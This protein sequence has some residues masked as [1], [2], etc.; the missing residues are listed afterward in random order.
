MTP[1]PFPLHFVCLC[2]CLSFHFSRSA[3]P[4]SCFLLACRVGT[5]FVARAQRAAVNLTATSNVLFQSSPQSLHLSSQLLSNLHIGLWSS[6]T[7]RLKKNGSNKTLIIEMFYKYAGNTCHNIIERLRSRKNSIRTS[8]D[9]DLNKWKSQI[10]HK[11]SPTKPRCWFWFVGNFLAFKR[12]LKTK[13]FKKRDVI[14]LK[15]Q[16][17]CSAL[18]W[19][20]VY[21]CVIQRLVTSDGSNGTQND[22]GH[23]DNEWG[24][25]SRRLG[26]PHIYI[27]CMIWKYVWVL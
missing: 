26:G 21:W 27:F 3:L 5:G 20:T 1:H 6:A 17:V 9:L 24:W 12:W 18:F 22:P 4:R 8:Q 15:R 23:P 10:N 2:P 16:Y 25:R 19:H 13:L 7:F 14:A 11:L